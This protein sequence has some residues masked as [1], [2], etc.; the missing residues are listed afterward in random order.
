[1]AYGIIKES[2]IIDKNKIISSCNKVEEISREFKKTADMLRNAANILN[3]DVLS[4]DGE[5][6]QPSIEKVAD[7]IAKYQSQIDGYMDSICSAANQVY[8]AQKAEYQ[9]YLKKDNK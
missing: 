4:V 3:K 9:E 6:M 5:T 8:R 1:M 2:Q 7:M